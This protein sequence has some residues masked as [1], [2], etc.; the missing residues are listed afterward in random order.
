MSQLIRLDE[1]LFP[2]L[3]NRS[4]FDDLFEL[5]GEFDRSTSPHSG[6]RTPSPVRINEN[7]D[8]FLLSIDLPGVDQDD[9]EITLHDGRLIVKAERKDSFDTENEK[10][11]SLFKFERSYNLPD[12]VS[13][14]IEGHLD[15]GVLQILLPKV[16]EAKPKKV[17]LK[18][19]NDS[20]S[21][22]E[23]FIGGS[24]KPNLQKVSS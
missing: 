11:E 12:N 6:L 8:A 21:F 19:G 20:Q 5:I 9:L 1:R 24:K 10:S 22:L 13:D 17:E 14:E 7:E 16:A 15:K 18:H 4:P 2:R 3:L 23:K